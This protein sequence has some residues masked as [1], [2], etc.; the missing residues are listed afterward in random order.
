MGV[1]IERKFLVRKDLLPR[2]LPEGDELEQGYL[3]MDPTVR[4]RLVT[5]HDGRTGEVTGHPGFA[6]FCQDRGITPRAC[7]PRRARTKGKIERGVGYV[8]RNALAGR[9]FASFVEL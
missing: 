1:E 8:K 6:I 2:E 7:R 5:A 4:V 9:S 3:G